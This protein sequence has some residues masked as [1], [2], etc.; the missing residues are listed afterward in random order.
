MVLN[1]SQ[2]AML[3]GQSYLAGMFNFGSMARFAAGGIVKPKRRHSSPSPHHPRHNRVR[4]K[5]RAA[6][7]I[8]SALDEIDE[9]ESNADRAYGQLVRQFDITQEQFIRTDPA[10][11]TDYISQPDINQRVSEIDQLITAR[12]NYLALLDEEKRELEKA[13][14]RLKKAIAA[15]VKAIKHEREQAA[16][17][18]H[19]IAVLGKQ[20][21]QEQAK[22]KPNPKIVNSLNAQITARG[23]SRSQH[24]S[25]V[26]TMSSTL[27]AFQGSLAGVQENLS[28]TLPMDR[29]DVTLDIATLQAERKDVTGTTLPTSSGGGGAG[30]AVGGPDVA[31]L[32]AQI[33]QLNLALAIQGAQSGVIGSFAKGTLSV[34]QTGLALVHAGESITPAGQARGGGGGDAGPIHVNLTLGG[35]LEPLARFITAT[36]DSPQ[37]ADRI[38]VHIGR[39]ATERARSS[40]A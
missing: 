8:L 39:R 25:N 9:N 34:P 26:G 4:S 10:T 28:D 21:G 17:D 23:N 19:M 31:A 14:A 35:P 16:S 12:D 20:L 2:Q 33:A 7:A 29:R 13:V 6:N 27:T 1:Q 40:R 37:V 36:V 3:G 5:S 30:S 15:L 32:I 18:A 24:L 22:K 11:G 38:S